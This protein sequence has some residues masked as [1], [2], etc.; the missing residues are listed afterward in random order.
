METL[1]VGDFQ[2]QLNEATGAIVLLNGVEKLSIQ[3]GEAQLAKTAIKFAAN[4]LNSP[5]LP[6]VIRFSPFTVKFTEDGGAQLLHAGPGKGSIS[7]NKATWEDLMKL[8]DMSVHRVAD[9]LKIRGGPRAGVSS[10]RMPDPL[11]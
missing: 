2:S 5:V 4:L 1:K 7:F 9:H 10:V 11:I 6:N 8:I 3:T